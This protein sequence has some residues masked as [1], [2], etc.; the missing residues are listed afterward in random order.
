[1]NKMR[2]RTNSFSAAAG[3]SAIKTK[4]ETIDDDAIEYDEYLHG[5]AAI[6]EATEHEL[7]KMST[8]SSAGTMASVEEED[9]AAAVYKK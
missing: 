9:A 5:P 2:R 7:E 6:D 1:M 4:F 3:H 8:S